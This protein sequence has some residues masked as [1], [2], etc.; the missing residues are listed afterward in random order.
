MLKYIKLS[1]FCN[2][3]STFSHKWNVLL[4]YKSF[5]V[6]D[7]LLLLW[8]DSIKLVYDKKQISKGEVIKLKEK[9][10]DGDEIERK[11]IKRLY[12]VDP[13]MSLLSVNFAT[14]ENEYLNE[15]TKDDPE[16]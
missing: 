3:F 7:L 16:K 2:H 6:S 1:P 5:P 9:Q 12:G 15:H 4:I 14:T 10:F 13:E 11:L 8:I